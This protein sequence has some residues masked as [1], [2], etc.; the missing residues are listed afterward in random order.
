MVMLQLRVF[1]A[2]RDGRTPTLINVF[3]VGTKIVIVLV[4]GHEFNDTGRIAVALTVATSASYV[5]G[6][7][8]GHIFLNRRL[9]N[10]GFRD[11]TNTVVKVTVASVIGGAAAF[12]VGVVLR[13]AL[14]D[15]RTGAIA[16]L[17]LGTLVGAAVLTV[18]LWRMRISEIED[19]VAM[20]RRR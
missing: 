11:V 20:V 16:T 6:A 14:G 5:V 18:V 3:M 12:G 1:Y 8:V 17:L 13:S 4:C 19:I 9:G 7:V 10:L 15:G 2:M